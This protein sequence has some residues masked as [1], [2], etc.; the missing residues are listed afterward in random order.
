M[1]VS[2]TKVEYIGGEGQGQI[3]LKSSADYEVL[4]GLPVGVYLKAATCPSPGLNRDRWSK[5]SMLY[6]GLLLRYPHSLI[7]PSLCSE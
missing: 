6:V 3:F 1:L 5:S 4:V 7:V 2:L